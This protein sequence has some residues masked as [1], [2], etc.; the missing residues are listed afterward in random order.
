MIHRLAKLIAG[1]IAFIG[2]GLTQLALAA[3]PYTAYV[4]GYF[5]ESPDGSQ[6]RFA[7]HLAYSAD[8]LNWIPL[9]QNKP[10]V[11][12]TLGYG[13]LRDPFILRKQDGSFV[14]MATN[15]TGQDMG[16]NLSKSI[17]VWDSPDLRSFN[18]GRLLQVNNS[19]TMHAW[20]PEAFWDASRGKYAILWSGNTDYNR[21]YVSYTTDFKTVTNST[22]LTV[23]H[24]PGHDIYDGDMLAYNGVNYFYNANGTIHGYQANSL[25]PGSFTNN[26][27]PTL[28]PL[29]VAIEA[30]TLVQKINEARW[31]LWGDSYAPRNPVFYAW[32][33]TNI[34][35]NAWTPLSMRKYNAPMNAK[36]STITKV[37]AAELNNLIAYWGNPTWNRLKS[38]NYPDRFVRHAS[39][40]GRID[41]APIDPLDDSRWRLVP[42]LADANAVSFESVGFP[43]YYLRHVNFKLVVNKN[44]STAA[45]KN[46]AT[47][48]KANGL[49]DAGWTSFRSFNF[50]DR[51]IR[52]VAFSLQ[53]DPITTSSP[54]TDKQDAT[55]KILY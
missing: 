5:T 46:D 1:A 22:N 12:A 29:G 48:Y 30:P 9:N 53:L 11:K 43:G 37:T 7:L 47:F 10:V 3:D 45:F 23:F 50:P 41:Q 20:A 21:I 36:H 32:E 55:F 27:V 44:D 17:H 13:A 54:T 35:G 18:N 8:G 49:A 33:T 51:Y 26:Y 15:M 6:N 4:M 52:H 38:Y 40:A 42:G 2:M 16:A 39:F 31:Y 24:D 25:N 34:A 14:V 19:S 28:S